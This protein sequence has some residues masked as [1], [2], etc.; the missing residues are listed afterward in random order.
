MCMG[1][2]EQRPRARALGSDGMVTGTGH[3]GRYLHPRRVVFQKWRWFCQLVEV[4]MLIERTDS[5]SCPFVSLKQP[6]PCP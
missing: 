1:G 4:E 6:T 3:A 5:L 2:V